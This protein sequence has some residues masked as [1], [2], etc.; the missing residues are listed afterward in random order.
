MVGARGSPASS[1]AS[2][3]LSSRDRL[4]EVG[5]RGGLHAVGAVAEVDLVQVHLEDAVL[6][7]AALQLQRQH[8]L[9]QLALEALVRREEEHLG[10]LLGDGA[11]AL[12][13]A[14]APVV[15]RRRARAMPMGSM[16]QW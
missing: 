8:R 16:P 7:V 5:P 12:H 6:R 4:A 9:L 10:Q 15:L 13:E 14:A 1:A 3:T 2:R 11:A